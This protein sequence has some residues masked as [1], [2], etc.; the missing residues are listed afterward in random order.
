MMDLPREV[1]DKALEENVKPRFL[2]MNKK[3]FALG[4]AAGQK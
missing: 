3:A 4:Y 1:W 2:E